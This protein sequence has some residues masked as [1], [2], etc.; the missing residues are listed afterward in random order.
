MVAPLPIPYQ[1]E[2]T[3]KVRH[4]VGFR[5]RLVLQVEV[6]YLTRTT[7]MSE[8]KGPFTYW[9]DATTK[10]LALVALDTLTQRGKE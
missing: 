8:A 4:R 2:L 5:K 10:D 9:R 7:P 3:G 1:H 6:Q